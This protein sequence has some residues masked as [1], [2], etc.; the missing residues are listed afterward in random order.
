MLLAEVIRIPAPASF[1]RLAICQPDPI[2]SI[3]QNEHIIPH[4]DPHSD[5]GFAE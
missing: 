2:Q 5:P 3:M 1:D 4:L